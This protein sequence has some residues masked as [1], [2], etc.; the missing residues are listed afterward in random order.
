MATT[1]T[2]LFPPGIL[3]SAVELDEIALQDTPPV[4][5]SHYLITFYNNSFRLQFIE[6]SSWVNFTTQ[7]NIGDAVYATH[8]GGGRLYYGVITAFE[9]GGGLLRVT[10]VTNPLGHPNFFS[11]D[12]QNTYF[13]VGG[14][15]NFAGVRV[16]P[17]GI[18]A[19]EFDEVSLIPSIGLGLTGSVSVIERGYGIALDS[20]GNRYGVGYIGY[21]TPCKF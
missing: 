8:G 2:K 12:G 9:D 10:Y 3:Q 19:K 16:S 21:T 20:S 5:G 11:T 13:E 1:L 18:Y 7:L 4:T 14:L 17:T 6:Q 15:T